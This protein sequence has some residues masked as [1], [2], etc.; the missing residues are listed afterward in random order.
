MCMDDVL[1]MYIH[2]VST[3]VCVDDFTHV[4]TRQFAVYPWLNLSLDSRLLGFICVRGIDL[5]FK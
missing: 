4:F 2:S 1:H 5:D 3:G